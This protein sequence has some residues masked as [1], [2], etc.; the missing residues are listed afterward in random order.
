MRGAP[1]KPGWRLFLLSQVPPLL[2][3]ALF[4][5]VRVW[6]ARPGQADAPFRYWPLLLAFAA[7][8]P[9]LWRL[10]QRDEERA[11]LWLLGYGLLSGAVV[12]AGYLGGLLLAASIILK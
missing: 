11:G 10:M 12:G 4:A 9:V 8:L 5:V 1:M 7:G 3:A 2:A 6:A